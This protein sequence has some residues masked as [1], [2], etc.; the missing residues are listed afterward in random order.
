MFSNVSLLLQNSFG[1]EGRLHTIGR[2]TANWVKTD[3]TVI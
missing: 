2:I 3:T 1:S